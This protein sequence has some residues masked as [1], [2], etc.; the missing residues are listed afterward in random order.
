VL[1]S[2]I[3]AEVFYRRLREGEHRVA[4]VLP[5]TEAVLVDMWPQLAAIRS[6]PDLVRFVAGQ[7]DFAHCRGIPF[8]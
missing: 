2:I 4:P 7:P 5:R 1:G 6:M 8:I 3:A